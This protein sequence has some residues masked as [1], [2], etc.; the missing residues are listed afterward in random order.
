MTK[1]DQFLNA[2][3]ERANLERYYDRLIETLA[4]IEE[5]FNNP[6]DIGEGFAILEVEK[7]KNKIKNKKLEV[8]G[9]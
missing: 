1:L 2:N 8:C 6:D 7:I 4:E 9:G 3:E 5:E